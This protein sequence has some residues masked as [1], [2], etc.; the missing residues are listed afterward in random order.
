MNMAD[1]GLIVLPTHRLVH[2]LPAF[3]REKLLADARHHFSITT[4]DNGA[5]NADALKLAGH[6]GP[7]N[8]PPSG[9]GVPGVKDAGVLRREID[10]RLPVHRSL[11]QLDV[12][13]LH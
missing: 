8:G 12:T 2:S 5:S 7:R 3:D 13:N 4:V 1:P 6:D 11:S 9:M 10:P